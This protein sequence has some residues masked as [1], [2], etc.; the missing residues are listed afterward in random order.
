MCSNK[1]AR[2]DES[3]NKLCKNIHNIYIIYNILCIYIIYIFNYVC[4]YMYIYIYVYIS[5]WFDSTT[6]ETNLCTRVVYS[7][8]ATYQSTV[9]TSCME[10]G[11]KTFVKKKHVMVNWIDGIVTNTFLHTSAVIVGFDNSLV[12]VELMPPMLPVAIRSWTK[13]S[14]DVKIVVF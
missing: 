3:P 6:K 12:I 10:M 9:Y 7:S 14:K 13:P 4:M 11:P 8:L 2:S 5:L 1:R